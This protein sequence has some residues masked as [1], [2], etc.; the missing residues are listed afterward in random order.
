[1][2]PTVILLYPHALKCRIKF[3]T[4]AILYNQFAYG[5]LVPPTSH[6]KET[7]RVIFKII[8]SGLEMARMPEMEMALS[9]QIKLTHSKTDALCESLTFK[10]FN[11][12]VERRQTGR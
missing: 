4:K 8:K 9:L 3:L 6:G 5:P 11:N 1:M 12:N 7:L 2:F 10:P